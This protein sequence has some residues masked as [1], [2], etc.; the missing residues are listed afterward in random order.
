MEQEDVDR[1][2]GLCDFILQNA[3]L[4]WVFYNEYIILIRTMKCVL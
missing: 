3:F 2:E 1:M 4:A